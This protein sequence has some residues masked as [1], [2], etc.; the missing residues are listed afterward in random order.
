MYGLGSP[1]GLRE[2]STRELRHGHTALV[3]VSRVPKTFPRKMVGSAVV[4]VQTKLVLTYRA[5]AVRLR[6]GCPKQVVVKALPFLEN[7]PTT[8]LIE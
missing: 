5:Q 7:T 8:R 2:V 6:Q 3:H 4:G 1:H